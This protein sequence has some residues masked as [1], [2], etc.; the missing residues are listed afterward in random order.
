MSVPACHQALGC[1]TLRGWRGA[2][3]R[4]TGSP[5]VGEAAWRVVMAPGVCRKRGAR[6][7][8]PCGRHGRAAATVRVSVSPEPGH[9]P[10][11]PP[12]PRWSSPPPPPSPGQ[13]DTPGDSPSCSHSHV[14]VFPPSPALTPRSFLPHASAFASQSSSTSLPSLI[15]THVFVSS[16]ALTHTSVTHSFSSRSFPSFMSQSFLPHAF[17]YHA[18]LLN[19]SFPSPICLSLPFLPSPTSI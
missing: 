2:G 15:L 19:F 13:E 4:G 3:I 16:L 12:P 5:R 7:S 10:L 6:C 18:R 17:S 9:A 11:G 8:Q 1:H 14:L